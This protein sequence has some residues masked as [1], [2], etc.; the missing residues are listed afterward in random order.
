MEDV[1]NLLALPGQRRATGDTSPLQQ[2]EVGAPGTLELGA[3]LSDVIPVPSEATVVELG[4]QGE[5]ARRL[6]TARVREKESEQRFQ[7]VLDTKEPRTARLALELRFPDGSVQLSL[8][9]DVTVVTAEVVAE[10]LR[11][12]KVAREKQESFE[13]KLHDAWKWKWSDP[14][15]DPPKLVAWLKDQPEVERASGTGA[16]FSGFYEISYKVRGAPAPAMIKCHRY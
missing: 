16:N 6:L 5:V 1:R 2:L 14:C 4:A 8:P 12:R 13:R 15:D 11:Q 7:F 9:V 3:R 10:Q